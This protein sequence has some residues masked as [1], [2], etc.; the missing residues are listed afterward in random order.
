MAYGLRYTLTQK[1]R[2]DSTLVINIYEKDPL[3]AT[4][5]TY[6]PT[7]ILIQPNSSEEEPL[8][9]II[10]SQLNFSFLISTQDDYDNFPNLLNADD[11]KYYVELVNVV[12]GS[13]N[14]KWKGFLFNDY[15]N[16]PFTTGNQEVNFICV[17]GLSYLKYTTYS[18]LEGNINEITNLLSVINTS[19][20]SIDYNSNTYLYSCCS[21][22]AAGMLDRGTNTNNEPFVQTYQYRRDFVGLDYFTILDNI[23]KS[24]GCRLFQ[25]EGNWWI[26]SINE[27]AGTTNYYTKYLLNPVVS[28]T[29]SG[30]LTTGI[31]IN[32]YSDGNVYFINNSQTKITRK[33][34]SRVIINN[35]FEY[36]DNYINNGDFKQRTSFTTPPVSF[37]SIV[38]GKGFINTYDLPDEQYNEVR[39]QAGIPSPPP[40]GGSGTSRL[41]MESIY[42]P[43]MGDNKAT[44]S[45][46]YACYNTNSPSSNTGETK[47][48][49]QVSVG[50]NTYFLN[51]DKKW[52]TSSSFITIPKSTVQTIN[53]SPRQKYSIEIPLGDESDN[54]VESVIGY[55]KVSFLV[56]SYNYFRFRNLRLQQTLANFTGVE[57]KRTLG[58]NLA[59]IK[60]IDVPYGGIY[61]EILISN[62]R[63]ALF[64]SSIV[65]LTN[66]YRYGKAGTYASLPQLLCRQYS[67]IFNKNL[68]TLEGDLGISESSNSSIYLNKKYTVVDSATDALS[69][70][71][72]TFLANRLT[73]DSYGDRTTSLQLLE[74]TNDDNLSVETIKYLES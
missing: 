70:N 59:L 49:I 7:S 6:E 23:V 27:M 25:Y 17:D 47:M 39:I 35:A 67:N 13:I 14:I 8:G 62:I 40:T 2:N 32:P 45:F 18:S 56:E 42:R 66:W 19:L 72:K 71:D 65:T 26:M 9:G 68:A 31:S 21:Y 61:P 41:E 46:D 60:G 36:V 50:A 5:K 58:T 55:V 48:F 29:G 28:L 22:F 53:R 38:T 20:Y 4:V 44:L 51:S 16:L 73:V 74:I 69:Y 43:I 33:G 34:F 57:V 30:T 37:T 15:I 11:R 1:L 3:V 52:V 24:F 54:F 12:G 63:G 64:N 10:S